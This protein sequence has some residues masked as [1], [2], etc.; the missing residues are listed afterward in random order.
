MTYTRRI[1]IAVVTAAVLAFICAAQWM[2]CK[3]LERYVDAQQ[4]YIEY[5]HHKCDS[6]LSKQDSIMDENFNLKREIFEL[7]YG[8][9]E[10]MNQF[11]EDKEM[12]V[13]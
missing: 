13:I 1:T 11:I 10:S 4:Q 12:K 7:K 5:W 6:I 8:E 3:E 2:V 9:E